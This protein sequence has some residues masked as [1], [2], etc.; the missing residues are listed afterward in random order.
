MESL[1]EFGTE[2]TIIDRAPNLKQLF[3]QHSRQ[4]RFWRNHI[5][6]GPFGAQETAT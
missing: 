2:R 1:S 3:C 6:Y 4:A 5:T